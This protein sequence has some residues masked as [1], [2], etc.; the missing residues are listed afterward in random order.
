MNL[1]MHF[2]S[3]IAIS[4]FNF[5]ISYKASLEKMFLDFDTHLHP[6]GLGVGLPQHDRSIKFYNTL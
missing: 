5:G 2:K 3:S 1:A 4:N 6:F